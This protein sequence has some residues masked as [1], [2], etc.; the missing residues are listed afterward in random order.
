MAP[1]NGP[2]IYCGGFLRGP[3][4]REF[5]SPAQIC[6]PQNREGGNFP[7]FFLGPER[8]GFPR[9]PRGPNFP[10]LE[11][12]L[13]FG[14]ARGAKFGRLCWEGGNRVRNLWR[15]QEIVG[16]KAG[17]PNGISKKTGKPLKLYYD[18]TSTGPDNRAE[19]D[20]RR[21][22]FAKLGIQLVIRST[23]YNRFQDKV[24]NGE[25][26]I[27]S[28]GWNADYPDPE[29]FLFLLYGANATVNTNGAGIN[30]SNYQNPKFDKL[31]EEIKRMKNSPNR[32]K[33]IRE[34]LQIAREDA[35]WVWGI[36]P[37][38]LALSHSWVYQI[39]LP[40]TAMGGN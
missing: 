35:P 4:K 28:W 3:P 16:R 2:P 37:K 6:S 1:Q 23:D 31:F 34:M 39:I 8:G 11:I 12:F 22:Q 19:M 20:W 30:S 26:Q 27:F 33:K 21:K 25:T 13:G 40:L 14:S 17:Y 32:L 18:T 15:L 24:R 38:S 5:F 36:H 7:F 9:P 10:A 29:N